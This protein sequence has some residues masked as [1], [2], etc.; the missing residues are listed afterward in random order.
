MNRYGEKVGCAYCDAHF[1]VDLDRGNSVVPTEDPDQGGSSPER[2]F[3]APSPFTQVL[4][5]NSGDL[6]E[7]RARLGVERRK[8]TAPSIDC[9]RSVSQP[10]SSYRPVLAHAHHETVRQ[11]ASNVHAGHPRMTKDAIADP[12]QINVP[13]VHTDVD[14]HKIENVGSPG[15]LGPHHFDVV[16][17]EVRTGSHGLPQEPPPQGDH[18]NDRC[19]PQHPPDRASPSLS[20][21][22]GAPHP[23][24]SA[25]PKSHHRPTSLTSGSNQI[26]NRSHTTRCTKSMSPFTSDARAPPRLRKKFACR[27]EI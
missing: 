9:V 12:L 20:S 19:D 14:T 24:V 7:L 10:D 6:R 15:G 26:W 5:W 21:Y 4:L 22:C 13:R 3:S 11:P 2:A 25:A 18:R 8:D 1:S 27:S 23:T 17:G 16:Q